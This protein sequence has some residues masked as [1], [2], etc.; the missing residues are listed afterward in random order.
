MGT[1]GSVECAGYVPNPPTNEACILYTAVYSPS[2]GKTILIRNVL[3][4]YLLRG[5]MFRSKSDTCILRLYTTKKRLCEFTRVI[6]DKNDLLLYKRSS[7]AVY[8]T[9]GI[10]EFRSL[11]KLLTQ[12]LMNPVIPI[13]NEQNLIQEVNK[14]CYLSEK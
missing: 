8:C 9:S 2:S 10:E 5:P 1:I 6:Y 14:R 4:P 12:Y 11:S 13:S 7:T 3:E